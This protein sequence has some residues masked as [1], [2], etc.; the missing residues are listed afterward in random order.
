VRDYFWR[1]LKSLNLPFNVVMYFCQDKMCSNIFQ[2]FVLKSQKKL[3]QVIL[4][5]KEVMVVSVKTIRYN[6]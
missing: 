6:N 4:S 3:S 1:E 5:E 2:F